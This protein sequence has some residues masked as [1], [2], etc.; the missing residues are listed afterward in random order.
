MPSNQN[1]LT[2]AHGKRD[3]A[4]RQFRITFDANPAPSVIIRLSDGVVVKANPGLPELTGRDNREVEGKSVHELG[5]FL[6]QEA[7]ERIVDVLKQGRSVQ[8]AE[9]RMRSATQG[10]RV[11]V[12]S[13][14]PIVLEADACAI[15][16]FADVTDL[17]RAEE[18]F[19][20]VFRLTPVPI[21]LLSADD[22]FLEVNES[23]TELTGYG[24]D[25]V[26]GRSSTELK[27]WSSDGDPK[28]LRDAL[29]EH[30]EFRDLELSLHT[31]AGETRHISG[32]GKVIDGDHD[33]VLLHVFQDV[34]ARKQSEEQFHK[35]VQAVMS[36]AS[37][38][39]RQLLGQL[40]NLKSG[41]AEPFEE[42][43]L[44]RR[45]RQVLERLAQGVNNEAI[46]AELGL[47]TQ[48]VRNYISTVHDKI[49]V[50]SRAEAI[51][52]ARERGIV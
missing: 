36:D 30:G 8:K 23:F 41:N 7:F 49:G 37:W 9:V 28:R 44:S 46:A 10:E 47:A 6:S 15:F 22:R 20:Q 35:A 34:T 2:E 11:T 31:K 52:W 14:N 4:Q 40:S 32:S 17:K 3:E 16:T 24:A 27:M 26:V 45:E 5:L 19:A 50:R 1:D 21:A 43:D 29:K 13:A 48:T 42:V 25:E 33:T 38:F 51:V 39:S 12:M 18:R